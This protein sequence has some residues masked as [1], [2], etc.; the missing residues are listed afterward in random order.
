MILELVKRGKMFKIT[1]KIPKIQ[2]KSL[3][4]R[5]ID[6]ALNILVADIKK[7]TPVDTGRL[8]NSI[9][10][11]KT[12]TG[13]EIY[14]N[15]KRNNEVAGYLIEGTDDHFIRPKGDT[16]FSKSGKVLKSP[17]K[18]KISARNRN[19]KILAWQTAGGQWRYSA[20]HMVSGI[21]KGYWKFQPTKSALTAFMT[22][23]KTFLKAKK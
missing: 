5:Q 17:S 9:R 7:R 16:S 6:E 23:L 4:P 13:G 8:R 14:I 21:R 22:R 19:K 20:G 10:K 18:R 15:G 3:T 1:A 12:A 11:R 2:I